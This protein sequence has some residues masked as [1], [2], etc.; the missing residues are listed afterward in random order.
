MSADRRTAAGASV[1]IVIYLYLRKVEP[2]RVGWGSSELLG[3]CRGQLG[4][5]CMSSLKNPARVSWYPVRSQWAG[6]KAAAISWSHTCF[7]TQDKSINPPKHFIHSRVSLDSIVLNLVRGH[8][9]DPVNY[10]FFLIYLKGSIALHIYFSGAPG[11]LF[12]I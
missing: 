5:G 6:Q 9:G 1:S 4:K 12:L 11:R 7:L 3:V 2:V 10:G 8:W